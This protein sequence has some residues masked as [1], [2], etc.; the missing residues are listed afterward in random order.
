VNKPFS[1]Y[2]HIPFCTQKCPYCDFNTYAVAKAP[3]KEYVSALLAE[4][5]Y[6]ASLPEW[7]G[8]TV[9]TIFFGGGTPSIF[10][11]KAIKHIL[12][13]I[14]R[15]FPLLDY[16]EVSLEA[17]PGT[18]AT[19]NL[20][21]FYDAGV[22]RLSF[23]GQSF[24]STTLKTLGRTHSPDQIIAAVESSRAALFSNISMDIIYGVPGQTIHDVRYDCEQAVQL[25]LPHASTYSLTIEKGT[26][27][28]QSYKR[29]VFKPIDD[30]L[31]LEMMDTIQ[32]TLFDRGHGL[33]R[34]EI[35]NFAKPGKEARHNMAYWN[36][37]D[38]LGIGAGAHSLCFNRRWSNM[39]LPQ[40]YINK[41]TTLGNAESWEET[42]TLR[43]QMF[44]YFFLGLRKIHGTSL[45]EFERRFEHPWEPLY[46]DL[47]DIL[48]T[49]RLLV[50]DGDYIRLS[51]RGLEI[52]DSVIE[53]FS[54][55]NLPTPV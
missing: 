42:L 25:D 14:T 18:V 45:T 4:L 1:I 20:S 31:S 24:N 16:V 49:E 38:Y 29:G 34:Y 15:L 41:A 17:N 35:S 21:E 33:E 54:K 30:D 19:D 27:F 47:I 6:R 50:H 7:R 32:Q 48:T 43:D 46:G 10:S 40:S 2:I 55:V 52:A 13:H 23:G 28:Y 26:P 9:Q 36:A 51:Q 53:N 11:G 3:E 12:S 37:D 39:A 22:N 5:D 44:E 8:R